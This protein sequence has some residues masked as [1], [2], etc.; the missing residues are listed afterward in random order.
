M[1]EG[2]Q[3]MHAKRGD[4]ELGAPPAVIEIE[5]ELPLRREESRRWVVHLM[6]FFSRVLVF[7]LGGKWVL[8]HGWKA[9]SRCVWII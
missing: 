3:V 2:P 5:S 9:Y 7:G 8:G 4:D 6:C 1:V